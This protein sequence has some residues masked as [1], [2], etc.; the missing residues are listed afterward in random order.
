MTAWARAG[1]ACVQGTIVA[2]FQQFRLQGFLQA[3]S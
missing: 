2:K 1:M 3:S